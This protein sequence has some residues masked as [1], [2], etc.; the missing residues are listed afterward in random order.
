MEEYDRLAASS[1]LRTDVDP[2]LVLCMILGSMM[3]LQ[4]AH[5]IPAT[6]EMANQVAEII[7]AGLKTAPGAQ[8]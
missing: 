7:S 4:F 6:P 3:M 2:E 8:A 5:G 1:G